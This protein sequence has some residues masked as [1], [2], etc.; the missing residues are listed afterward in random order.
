[1]RNSSF[2]KQNKAQLKTKIVDF[3]IIGRQNGATKIL[4]QTRNAIALTVS[5]D[6]SKI[7]M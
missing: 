2:L 1:M 4:Y 7:K 5:S 6:S 3:R